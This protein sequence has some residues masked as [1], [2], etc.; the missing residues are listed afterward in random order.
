MAAR[1]R[2]R[3]AKKSKARKAKKGGYMPIAVLRHNLKRVAHGIRRNPYATRQ[4]KERV[5]GI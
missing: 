4:D 1:K 3:K 2:R 5:Q